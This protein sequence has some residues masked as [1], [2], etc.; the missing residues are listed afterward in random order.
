M[1]HS[2]ANLLH[3]S[4]KLFF[5]AFFWSSFIWTSILQTPSPQ[6]ETSTSF[7]TYTF[8]IIP[9]NTV[10]I[11]VTTLIIFA[12]FFYKFWPFFNK[13]FF[14]LL[15]F[16]I[17]S[18][19]F[20]WHADILLIIPQAQLLEVEYRHNKPLHFSFNYWQSLL[21]LCKQL[22]VISITPST[23]KRLNIKYPHLNVIS[24][25]IWISAFPLKV[26]VN[27]YMVQRGNTVLR[28]IRILDI[29]KFTTLIPLTF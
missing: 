17:P 23:S 11:L 13:P 14:I 28:T 16:T 2:N 24:G 27:L 19:L 18:T 4:L 12:S 25:L 20:S 10:Q 8:Q 22:T 7:K 6:S 26:Q 1:V 9:I 21:N 29:A 15:P 3:K 5:L